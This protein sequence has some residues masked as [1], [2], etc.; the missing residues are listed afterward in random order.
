[1][2]WSVPVESDIQLGREAWRDLRRQYKPV[3]DKWGVNRI[4]GDLVQMLPDQTFEWDFGVVHAPNVV[5]AFCF[6]GG[7]VRVTD[8]LLYTLN[9]SDGEVAALLGHE[10]GHVL[11][12]HAQKR[13]I[14]KELL[15]LLMKALVY[16]DHDDDQETF[17]QALGELMMNS[18]TYLGSLSFSRQD[19]YEA[20]ASSWELLVMTGVYR[21]HALQSLLSKLW[22][23]ENGSS[24]KTSWESTHP[25][26]KDRIEALQKKWNDLPIKDR[27][28]LAGYPV[29]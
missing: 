21:P 13:I 25:G 24:G 27:K 5:N 2:L 12:R 11:H 7:I 20:D 14:Q 15:S 10:I 29:Q 16:E 8:T 17:G 3:H 22:S 26:T 1:V 6:P 4:G 19:E 28:R 18:A 23:L 9:L